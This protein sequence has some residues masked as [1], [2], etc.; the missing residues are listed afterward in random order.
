M[1][2]RAVVL[3]RECCGGPRPFSP[4]LRSP[5]LP[6]P[7]PRRAQS[8]PFGART[9]RARAPLPRGAGERGGGGGCE[10]AAKG[11]RQRPPLLGRA[12]RAPPPPRPSPKLAGPH[13]GPP[14]GKKTKEQ[15][16]GTASCSLARLQAPAAARSHP[17]VPAPMV[18]PRL[19]HPCLSSCSSRLL[20]PPRLR[21]GDPAGFPSKSPGPRG[22]MQL[23][24]LSHQLGILEALQGLRAGFHR[25]LHLPQAL[26]GALGRELQGGSPFEE[27]F[28]QLG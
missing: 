12:S 1:S 24:G 6:P 8:G 17:R 23:D 5:S 7:R 25:A 13:L 16:E 21:G 15:L 27:L 11:P 14:A 28:E 19:P 3:P 2:P 18:K 4:R 9:S 20:R 22:A 26:L 10:L